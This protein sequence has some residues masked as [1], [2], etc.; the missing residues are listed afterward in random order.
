MKGQFNNW[1]FNALDMHNPPLCY[2]T[3]HRRYMTQ[4]PRYYARYMTQHRHSRSL[5]SGNL[6]EK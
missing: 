4:H 3:Q 1:L 2:M 5:L 6:N